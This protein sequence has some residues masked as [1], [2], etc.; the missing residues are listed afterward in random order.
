MITETGSGPL[1]RAGHLGPGPPA[2]PQNLPAR[3]H[4]LCTQHHTGER[5]T[6]S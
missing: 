2:L 3:K 4:P 1:G 5:A 6:Y